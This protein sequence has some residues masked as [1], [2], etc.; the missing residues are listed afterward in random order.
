MRKIELRG[1]RNEKKKGG[2]DREQIRTEVQGSGTEQRRD[3]KET[4]GDGKETNGDD[5][6]RKGGE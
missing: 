4:K 1:K 2:E 5:R 6:R 3:G